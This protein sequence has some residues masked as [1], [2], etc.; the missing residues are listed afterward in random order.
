MTEPAGIGIA[1][2]VAAITVVE[3]GELRGELVHGHPAFHSADSGEIAGAVANLI[4]EQASVIRDAGGPGVG[5]IEREW[6]VGMR[7][8][9][10][11]I[12]A[13][14]ESHGAAG[15]LRV[16]REAALPELVTDDDDG[17]RAGLALGGLKGAPHYGTGAEDVEKV[18]GDTGGGELLGVAHPGEGE[19][20]TCVNGH[21]GEGLVVVAHVLVGGNRERI[22]GA[23][24]G[25]RAGDEEETSGIGEREGAEEE[26]VDDAEHGGVGSDAEG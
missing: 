26:R 5:D 17:E 3:D 16:R 12:D 15:D 9:D 8:P 25:T 20:F 21:S 4:R 11:G 1:G 6:E 24:R 22:S 2:M 7:H 23:S 19:S 18:G 10:D 14:A 13:L